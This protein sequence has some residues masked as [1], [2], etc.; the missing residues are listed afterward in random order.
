MLGF[1][2]QNDLKDGRQF[3]NIHVWGNTELRDDSEYFVACSDES[4]GQR[5][6]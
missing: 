6:L 2:L 1:E 4:A 3:S 5:I